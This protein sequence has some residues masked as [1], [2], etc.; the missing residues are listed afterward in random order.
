MQ[1]GSCRTFL[2]FSEEAA[3]GLAIPTEET[4]RQIDAN[5]KALPS[6]VFF[7]IDRSRYERETKETYPFRMRKLVAGNWSASRDQSAFGTIRVEPHSRA[8]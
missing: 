2:A 1:S 6:Y 8:R 5:P 4:K 3:P 7:E